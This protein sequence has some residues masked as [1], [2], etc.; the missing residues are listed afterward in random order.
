[1][2]DM[3]DMEFGA[4]TQ[5]YSHWLFTHALFRVRGSLLERGEK[6]LHFRFHVKPIT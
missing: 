3:D 5:C 1:M 6:I 4:M 2:D